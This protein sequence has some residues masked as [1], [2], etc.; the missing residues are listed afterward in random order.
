MKKTMVGMAVVGLVLS[1]LYTAGAKP[2]L[3]MDDGS[4]FI[5]VVD[6]G[7]GDGSPIDGMVAWTG[8]ISPTWFIAVNSGLTK[9]AYGS[10]TA[11][12]M[13][14]NFMDGSFGA[15][16]LTIKWTD[17]GFTMPGGTLIANIGGTMAFGG[18]EITYWTEYNGVKVTELDF[19]TPPSGYTGTDTATIPANG[20]FSL[21]QV[22]VI[23]HYLTQGVSVSSG[24][25]ELMG[26]AIP[27]PDGGMTAVLL[28]FVL[29]GVEGLNRRFKSAKK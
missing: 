28:G 12:M 7:A 17:D 26:F 5:K 21:T 23:K 25:A 1:G 2:F 10:A 27:I 11:P 13:D 16:T 3:T 22:I 15:G 9:P 18:G 20:S 8:L 6:G 19:R 4:T 14:L 24:N 29:L